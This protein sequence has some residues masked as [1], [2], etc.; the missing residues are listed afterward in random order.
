MHIAKRKHS[1]NHPVS[2][3]EIY[4]CPLSH[5]YTYF[6]F[7][8]TLI[9]FSLTITAIIIHDIDIYKRKNTFQGKVL[10]ITTDETPEADASWIPIFGLPKEKKN[11]KEGSRVSMHASLI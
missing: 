1:K 11:M 10:Q 2:H 8:S 6:Q 7:S 3:E 9:Y 4:F 5:T